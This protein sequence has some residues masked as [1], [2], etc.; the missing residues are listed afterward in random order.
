MTHLT[1]SQGKA[2]APAIKYSIWY[3][4]GALGLFIFGKFNAAVVF[5]FISV[6]WQMV[7]EIVKAIQSETNGD[8]N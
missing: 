1:R 4:L 6:V 2:M 7:G 8:P 5:F 3:A